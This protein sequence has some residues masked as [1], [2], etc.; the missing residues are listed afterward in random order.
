MPPVSLCKP[1][2][3]RDKG[4][5]RYGEWLWRFPRRVPPEGHYVEASGLAKFADGRLRRSDRGSVPAGIERSD[6]L[7]GQLLAG[8][9]VDH[10]LMGHIVS[11]LNDAPWGSPGALSRT[12]WLRTT[13]RDADVRMAR[14]GDQ[15]EVLIARFCRKGGEMAA[16]QMCFHAAVHARAH[17][18]AAQG[19]CRQPRPRPHRPPYPSIELGRHIARSSARGSFGKAFRDQCPW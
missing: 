6:L 15:Q 5:G 4:P 9:D 13:G 11:T 17:L 8:G 18:S 3:G 12:M 19:Q 14:L 2:F 10:K 16:R 1:P 7:D